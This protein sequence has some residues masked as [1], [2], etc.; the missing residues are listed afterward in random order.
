MTPTRIAWRVVT[1][2]LTLIDALLRDIRSLPLNDRQ[3]FL[4][5][6]RNVWN[7]E[8]EKLDQAL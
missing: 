2:R 7:A 6:R 5:D 4:S 8:S 3:L 1:D